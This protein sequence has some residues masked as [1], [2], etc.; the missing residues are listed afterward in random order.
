MANFPDSVTQF[1]NSCIK[2]ELDPKYLERI[3]GKDSH[4]I[5][6]ESG[7]PWLKLN[8]P[9]PHEEMYQEA[10]PWVDEMIYQ[11]YPS[12]FDA[13]SGGSKQRGWKTIC[14]HGLGKHKFDRACVY[15]Y[16]HEDEAPYQWTEV[17]E[18]CPITKSF[19][20]S[21]PYEK[22]YRARFTCLE[23]GG[24][25][26]PHIGR[27]EHADYSHKISFAL[28]HPPK[29]SFLMEDHGPIPW[30]AGRGFLLNVDENYHCVLN[31]SETP[32]I[33]LITMGKPDWKRLNE[34]TLKSYYENDPK[35]NLYDW[36]NSKDQLP[37]Q[38]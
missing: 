6:E 18:K 13:K 25:S 10:L 7:L 15:G 1:Y 20:E 12:L 36:K 14:V 35:E 3:P 22:L 4:W 27:K 5:Y 24:Y 29:W 21:L 37:P 38:I 9:V 31:M 34:I 26:A 23:P 17:A 33:H 19:L 11:D 2:K 30:E 32:R 8:I 16:E 28:N